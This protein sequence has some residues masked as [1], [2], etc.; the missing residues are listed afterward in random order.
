MNEHLRQKTDELIERAGRAVIG[1]FPNPGDTDVNHAFC[2]SIG[3]AAKGLP[4]ILIVGLFDQAGTAIINDLSARML[5]RGRA[6]DH[7][8]L[9]DLGG[10]FPICIIEAS[11]A[12]K[13]IYTVQATNYFCH[14]EYEV[15]QAVMCDKEGRF[16]W[17]K[18]CAAPYGKVIVYQR[19]ANA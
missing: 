9:V 8:E 3:N 18:G 6:L 19:R 2:Y 15:L 7:G 14:Q 13:E 16:P 1:V 17:D 11:E 10:T 4:E 5:E 12:V